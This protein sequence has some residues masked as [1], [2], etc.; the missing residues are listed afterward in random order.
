MQL[1]RNKIKQ[2][3]FR[4]IHSIIYKQDLFGTLSMIPQQVLMIQDVRLCYTCEVGSIGDM[5][6][7]ETYGNLCE[8]GVL[9]EEFKIVEKKG[10]TCALDFPNIF[11]REWIKMVLSRI[12]DNSIWLDNGPIKITMKIVRRVIGYPTLDLSKTL[13]S[14]EKEVIKRNTRVVWNKQGMTIDTIIDPLIYFIVRIIAH[15]FYQSSRLNNVPCI[16]VDVGYKIVMK[17]HTYDL[18]E[19]QLQQLT[20]NLGTIRKT[21]NA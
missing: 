7:R 5:E 2:P 10:L 9:K 20:E 18:T 3:N 13:K 1:I 11:K 14:E 16:A 17:D 21:K 6:I 4:A 19:L 8:N 15:K 12:H